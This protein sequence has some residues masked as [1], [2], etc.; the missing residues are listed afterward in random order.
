MAQIVS[1]GRFLCILNRSSLFSELMNIT[2]AGELPFLV[3]LKAIIV[4]SGHSVDAYFIEDFLAAEESG[5]IMDKTS[6]ADVAIELRNES[7]Q[8]KKMLLR[9][10]ANNVSNKTMVLTSA[11]ATSA[12]QAAAWFHSPGRVTGFGLMPPLKSG[13]TVEELY[14][15]QDSEKKPGARW[16]FGDQSNSSL[17]SWLIVLDW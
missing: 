5:I 6:S 2:I 1:L 8:A 7:P 10:H 4:D 16:P 11:L 14:P 17:S 9:S 15:L 3:L 12:T 13:E